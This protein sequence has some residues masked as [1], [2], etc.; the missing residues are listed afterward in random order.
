MKRRT[1][2]P[3]IDHAADRARWIDLI[4]QAHQ[5]VEA[6][7][8]EARSRLAERAVTARN[9][10]TPPAP[11]PA[12]L[13]VH[14]FAQAAYAWG[15]QVDPVLRQGAAAMMIQAAGLADQVIVAAQAAAEASPLTPTLPAA[16]LPYADA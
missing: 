10:W 4:L 13:I 6:D 8:P 11:Y 3:P 9:V 5:A 2:R 14:A 16:R 12:G 1:A 7:T 15:R